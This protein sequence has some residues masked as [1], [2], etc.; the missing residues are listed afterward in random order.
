MR[1]SVIWGSFFSILLVIGVYTLF[2]T[3]ANAEEGELK[4]V[5]SVDL[6]RYTGTWYEIARSANESQNGCDENITETYFQQLDGDITVIR[7]CLGEYGKINTLRGEAFINDEAGNAKLSVR[8]APKIVSFLPNVWS[9]YWII[10][11]DE[12]YK[13]SVVSDPA[14]GMLRIFSRMPG[15][16]EGT[17]QNILQTLEQKGFD[18]KNLVKTPQNIGK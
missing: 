8:F 12:D 3:S 16:D 2:L 18:S 4:T 10:D 6:K 9:D 13:Y 7:K 15:M 14:R 5:Q 11:L 1:K 17:F